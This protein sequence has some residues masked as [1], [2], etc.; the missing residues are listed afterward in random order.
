MLL[1]FSVG[2]FR[3]INERK[4]LSFEAT[5]QKDF[6][7]N[8]FEK[9][10]YTILKSNVLYGA[11]SSGKSNVINAIAQMKSI[12]DESFSLS[13]SDKINVT[14]FLLNAESAK[15][16]SSFEILFLID[17]IRYRYGF[18][19]NAD[20]VHNEYLFIRESK[21]KEEK[22]LFARM[23]DKIEVTK[24]FTEG[25]GIEART[26]NNT[27]FLTVVNQFNGAISSKIIDWFVSLQIFS[28]LDHNEKKFITSMFLMDKFMEKQIK[29]FL[30]SLT[31]GFKDL[32]TDGKNQFKNQII[33]T[34]HSKFDKNGQ[35]I[36][37]TEF[38][39]ISQ[40]SSGTNKIYDIAGL[41]IFSLAFGKILVIDE[42]DAKLHPLLTQAIVR[43]F[44]SE[45][46]N[47]LN[48]QLVFSTHDT[49]LLNA[50]LFRRDQIYFTEKNEFEET[51]L[52]SLA[53]YKDE[54]GKK[55]RNDSSIEKNYIEGRYGAIPYIG[56]F[57][58]L[59]QDGTKREN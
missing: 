56:D 48:A 19:V 3:S 6:P 27:L 5:S 37:T 45:E 8:K 17:E 30:Q 10:G 41:I 40:E 20:E 28:G 47:P 18:E 58:K 53:E 55:V 32:K 59:I 14:P 46:T 7:Q 16:P 24:H 43:L 44:H 23:F 39:L 36:G 29:N 31:L 33:K 34:I 38:D 25:E 26:K 4:T 49:N 54:S 1:E 12:I 35:V 52:Y 11:N 51:D 50:C 2:N 22:M 13:T 42:L 9:N 15:L 57:S 21:T